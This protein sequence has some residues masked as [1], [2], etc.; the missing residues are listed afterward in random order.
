M[1]VVI[2]EAYWDPSRHKLRL[3]TLRKAN[4][5][6]AAYSLGGVKISPYLGLVISR[7]WAFS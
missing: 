6:P 7:A 4:T 1:V 2:C 3:F 5:V